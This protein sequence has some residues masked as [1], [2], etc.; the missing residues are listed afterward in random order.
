MDLTEVKLEEFKPQPLI[1]K[2]TAIRDAMVT[3]S[4]TPVM[5]GE[6]FVELID[7]CGSIHDALAL[8]LDVNVKEITTDIENRLA[9]ADAAAEAARAEQQKM[10]ALRQLVEELTGA[11]V[12]GTGDAKPAPTKVVIESCPEEVTLAK[13][14]RPKIAARAVPGY[15]DGGVLF[16]ADNRALMITPDGYISP[17]SPGE[18]VVNVVATAKTTVY[19]QLTIAVVPPRVRV[20][21]AGGMRLD[22]K[23]NIRLT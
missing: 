4:V 8:F 3:K 5:V 19:K 18:S 16:I 21:S 10:E 12:S 2:A 7:A 20:L 9:G 17:V 23:G 22:S 15:T 13:G 11:L 14:V 1:E 6:L